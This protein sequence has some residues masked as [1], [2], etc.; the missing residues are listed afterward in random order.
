MHIT[1]FHILEW[2][3]CCST[4]DFW[5]CSWAS[6]M[7]VLIERVVCYTFSGWVTRMVIKVCLTVWLWG[8]SSL[9]TYCFLVFLYLSCIIIYATPITVVCGTVQHCSQRLVYFFNVGRRASKDSARASCCSCR[10]GWPP[11]SSGL[12]GPRGSCFLSSPAKLT[13]RLD[14]LWLGSLQCL[15][16]ALWLFW[17]VEL[18]LTQHDAVLQIHSWCLIQSECLCPEQYIWAWIFTLF[19]IDK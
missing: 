2:H 3:F 5:Q 17:W 9:S 16:L 19:L 8:Y 14:S 13:S 18:F 15:R 6:T 12:L 4:K 1:S 10:F 7:I 11:P